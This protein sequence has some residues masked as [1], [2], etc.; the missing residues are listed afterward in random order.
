M[1]INTFPYQSP[2]AP[3]MLFE[4]EDHED[5]EFQFEQLDKNIKEFY[6]IHGNVLSLFRDD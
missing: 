6:D 5:Y 2:T 4:I 3:P 1:L